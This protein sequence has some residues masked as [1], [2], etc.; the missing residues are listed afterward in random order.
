MNRLA[1]GD[2]TARR[3]PCSCPRA[4]LVINKKIADKL[5]IEIPA[6]ALHAANKV[7]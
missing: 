4:E 5:E 6:D 7:F 1:A 2:T 3:A